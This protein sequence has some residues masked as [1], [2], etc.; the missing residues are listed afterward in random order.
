MDYL[1]GQLAEAEERLEQ[2]LNHIKKLANTLNPK[3][4]KEAAF[5]L[6]FVEEIEHPKVTPFYTAK[7]LD[8]DPD[9]LGF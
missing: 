5:A 6:M 2:A 1:I 9:K 8:V 3:Q 7:F 4:N